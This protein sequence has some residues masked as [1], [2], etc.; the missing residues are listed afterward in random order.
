MHIENIEDFR[1][2]CLSFKG[3]HEKMPFGKATS[4]YDRNLL[5]FYV[6]DKWFCFVNIEVF[7]FC[8]IRCPQDKILDLVEQYEGI[9]PGY[10]MNKKHWIS[11]YF[12][13]DVPDG[14]IQDLVRQSYESVVAKMTRKE[15]EMLDLDGNKW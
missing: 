9:R 10:H 3:V 11:V 14:K 5:V 7:D 2:F 15:R 4:T 1:R 6:C 8:N 13:A 12:H